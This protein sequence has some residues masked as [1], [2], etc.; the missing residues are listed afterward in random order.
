MVYTKLIWDVDKVK[1]MNKN[2]NSAIQ[3]A[4]SK[5]WLM[6]SNTSKELAPYQTGNLR[7]SISVDFMNV[8]RWFVVVWSPEPYARRREFEN[9]K[10][11]DRKYY[12]MRWYTTNETK[13]KDI[14]NQAFNDNLK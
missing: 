14:I 4:L 13:I 11:P 5:I 7:R 12:I 9:Y 3:V 8:Q 1:N 6:V 2:V 10:N